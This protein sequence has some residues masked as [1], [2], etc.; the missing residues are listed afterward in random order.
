MREDF[1]PFYLLFTPR[2]ILE[3]EDGTGNEPPL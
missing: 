1:N 3:K 2:I